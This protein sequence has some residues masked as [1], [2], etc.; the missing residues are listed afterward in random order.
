MCPKKVT[1]DINKKPVAGISAA[2]A[3]TITTNSLN[4][5]SVGLN[6]SPGTISQKM[7]KAI[8]LGGPV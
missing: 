7:Y 1:D 8:I 6:T 2:A 5:S 3:V 4:T